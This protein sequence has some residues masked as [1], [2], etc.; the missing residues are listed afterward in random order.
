MIY[1]A[2]FVLK[3]ILV[4]LLM[5]LHYLLY[6]L[7][8]VLFLKVITYLL[9]GNDKYSVMEAKRIN[10]SIISA[11]VNY[12]LLPYMWIKELS[13]KRQIKKIKSHAV[14][15]IKN[16]PEDL[17]FDTNKCVYLTDSESDI[18]AILTKISQPK[19]YKLTIPFVYYTGYNHCV[20]L[21]Y[22]STIYK[23]NN[24]SNVKSIIRFGATNNYKLTTVQQ[25]A[26]IINEHL[27][28]K[29]EIKKLR[30]QYVK[31]SKLAK[32]VAASDIYNERLHIYETAL[33][34]I[35]NCS[36]QA[37]QLQQ[38]YTRLVR[39]MLIGIKVAEEELKYLPD[40]ETSFDLQY[41]R[42][43]EEYNIMKDVATAYYQLLKDSRHTQV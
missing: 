29:A 34:K 30:K 18:F 3:L 26:P 5:F 40:R 7:I 14:V 4:I 8:T 35:I 13:T 41:Q 28:I 43:Q 33:R 2:I 20:Q 36:N 6:L 16:L 39:E 31:I 11:H 21:E 19:T 22:D 9:L 12:L 27:Q 38:S 25:L 1:I 10:A 15:L 32:L 17:Y 23:L 24:V 42:I 37:E